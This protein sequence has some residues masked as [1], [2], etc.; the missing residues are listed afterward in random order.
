MLQKIITPSVLLSLSLIV[1]MLCFSMVGTQLEILLEFNREKILQGE[2]W[3]L[4]TSNL[5][6]YGVAHVLMNIAAFIII[7]FTLLKELSLKPYIVLLLICAIAVNLGTLL[8]NPELNFYRGFSGALHGLIVAGLLLNSFRN[9]WLS[10]VCVL[11][12]FAKIIHE[13]QADFQANELQALLPVKVAV[14]SH[15]YGAIAGLIFFGL[16]FIQLQLRKNTKSP[17]TNAKG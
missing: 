14:D 17:D 13:H 15:L 8:F 4:I 2:Y 11:L 1:L 7:S 5:V 10:Y 6:H 12:V 3:R 9:R 16:Y